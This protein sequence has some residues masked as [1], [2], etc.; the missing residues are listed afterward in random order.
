[1]VAGVGMPQI[2]AVIE[3]SKAAKKKVKT[4]IADGG[5]KY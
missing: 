2:T 1:V 5:I 4:I 3:C